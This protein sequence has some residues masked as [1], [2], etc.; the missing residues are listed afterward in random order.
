MLFYST[1]DNFFTLYVNIVQLNPQTKKKQK[2]QI[3]QFAPN[4]SKIIM[5][6][7]LGLNSEKWKFEIFLEVSFMG[8]KYLDLLFQHELLSVFFTSKDNVVFAQIPDFCT[9][10]ILH[11]SSLVFSNRLLLVCLSFEEMSN[12]SHS[13]QAV[14]IPVFT[15]HT[16]SVLP[17]SK[18]SDIFLDPFLYLPFVYIA[19]VSYQ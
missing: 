6:F 16:V 8:E 10:N 15:F 3:F 1:L 11:F 12:V 19:P 18:R 2:R 17:S 14:F 5:G 9:T 4:A 13:K 7:T